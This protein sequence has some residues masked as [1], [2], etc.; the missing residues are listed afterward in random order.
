LAAGTVNTTNNIYLIR[1]LVNGTVSPL[2]AMRA[3]YFGLNIPG[4]TSTFNLAM[5]YDSLVENPDGLTE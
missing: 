2:I 5:R 1:E 3:G 4:L